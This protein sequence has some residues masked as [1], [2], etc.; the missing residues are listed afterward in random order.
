V[1]NAP[2]P[3]FRAAP[4]FPWKIV[5]GIVC[6][7][8]ILRG[9]FVAVAPVSGFISADLDLNAAQI[10]LLTSLPVLC[11][12]V[13]T[14]FASAFIG[15][16]GANFAITVSIAGVALGTIVRS[17]GG[18]EA[19]FAG[20]VILGAFVAVGNVV[21]PVIIRR[22]VPGRRVGMVSGIYTSAMNV[23]TM[24]TSIVT[25]PLAEHY[26]WRAALVAWVGL[27]VIAGVAW[28]IAVGPRAAFRW[29][30]VRPA[31]EE[32]A[33]DTVAIDT[34]AV[35]AIPGARPR[36]WRSLSAVLLALAFCGQT[37]SY[38]GLTAWLPSIL[39]DEI[40]YSTTAAGTSSSVFQIAAVVGAIA[41]PL[42]AHRIGVPRTLAIMG[43]AWMACPI[44]LLLAPDGWPAW[45]FLGGA[46]QGGGFTVLFM[47]VVQ[48]AISGDHTR[49]LSAMVQGTGYVVGAVGPLLLGA[50][51]DATGA[52]QAPLAAVVGSTMLYT[53][54][55]LFGAVRATRAI[56][57][58][59]A[60]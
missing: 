60:P 34:A 18:V 10:G 59:R 53:V 17:A 14:P 20:T 55:G 32:G 37:F 24:V 56:R 48:L 36:T 22:D 12:A 2:A 31:I 5:I 7:A 57:A 41:A 28:L 40:G 26:G 9:L 54:A 46:A 21:M 29:G 51:H 16:A 58:R 49:R 45:G 13:I 27:A 39:H 35:P 25:A 52:W 23:S 3:A 4:R 1:T 15:R 11:F 38:F 30:P 19:L 50:L 33:V 8:L 6:F 44:G 42:L 47:L 43:A